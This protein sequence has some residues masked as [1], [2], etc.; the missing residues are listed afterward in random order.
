MIKLKI[1]YGRKILAHAARKIK[2]IHKIYAK[3]K[4]IPVS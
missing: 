2:S 3:L 4:I 1:K